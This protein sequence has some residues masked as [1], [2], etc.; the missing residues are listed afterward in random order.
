MGG[1]SVT[2]TV[3]V[4]FRLSS[5]HHTQSEPITDTHAAKRRRFTNASP[6]RLVP[7]LPRH[8]RALTAPQLS[9]APPRCDCTSTDLPARPPARPGNG[10]VIA[11]ALA[12][13]SPPRFRCR[14][15]DSAHHH[16]RP[17]KGGLGS[18]SALLLPTD[19]GHPPARPIPPAPPSTA[20]PPSRPAAHAQPARRRRV[21][22]PD[23]SGWLRPA[24][25]AAAGSTS[26]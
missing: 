24:S 6:H 10:H 7:H 4:L 2:V 17:A 26:A 20:R 9:A 12:C 21:L 19:A 3:T 18:S 25:Y 14:P 15:L 23:V 13:H 1:R 11:A 22:P 8:A 16:I 5:P